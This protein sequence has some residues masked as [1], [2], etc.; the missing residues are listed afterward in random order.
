MKKII[1]FL[2]LMLISTTCFVLGCAGGE[3]HEYG[4][5]VSKTD[6]TCTTTGMKAHYKCIDCDKYLDEDKN[7]VAYEDLIIAIDTNAHEYD[8]QA[9]IESLRSV[10]KVCHA[11]ATVADSYSKIVSAMNSAEND[12]VIYLKAG[13]YTIITVNKDNTAFSFNTHELNEFE[14]KKK[15]LL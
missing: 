12:D 14:K 8:T 15:K 10:C 5:L 4:T 11:G 7:E 2:M 3:T 13:N 1:C 9:P 6:A